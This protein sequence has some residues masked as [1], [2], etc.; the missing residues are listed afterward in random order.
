MKILFLVHEF[1]PEF[2]GGTEKIIFNNALM[3]QKN[4][5][6]VKVITYSFYNDS[7]YDHENMGIFSKEFTYQGIPV[8]AYKYKNQ[9]DDINIGLGNQIL[10]EF[11]QTIIDAEAP[12]IIH[13][14]HPMRVH[15]F[16]RAAKDKNIPYIITLTDFFLLCPKVILAPDNNSLCSGPKNG[17]A[18][19]VLCKEFDEVFIQKRLH[20]SHR[21]LSNSKFIISPSNFVA[22]KFKQEFDNV[23]V[24]IINHGIRFKN[25]QQNNNVYAKGNKLTFGYAGNLAY[26]KGVH[27]L[28]KA[29]GEIDNENLKLAIYGSGPEDYVNK[30]KE[31]SINDNR[32]TFF[33]AYS[34]EQ[35]KDIFNNIDV[36]ITP[37]VCYENYPLV[38]HEALASGVPVIASNLGGMAEKITDGFNGFTFKPADSEDLNK[39]M[40]KII[41]NIELLNDLKKNIKTNMIIPTIE[42]EAYQYFK[43]YNSILQFKRTKSDSTD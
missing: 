37:S 3:A 10:Y 38:L 35:L 20:E 25:I 16:V 9:P 13:V 24:R 43:I 40:R 34:T 19:K 32:I 39:Y 33:G 23:D 27:I 11:A 31:I 8:F 42:Q 14:G 2:H 6:K 17:T 26:H 15:E 7:F 36:L 21:I 41:D 4:G 22:L 5:F 1:Y 29:F 12:D 30:L 28:L 18:C